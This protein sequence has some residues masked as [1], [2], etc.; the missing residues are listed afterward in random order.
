MCF[1]KAPTP[2][3]IAALPVA[4]PELVDD[5]ALADREKERERLR[6]AK[7]Y[8]STMLASGSANGSAPATSGTKTALDS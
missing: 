2:K 6:K 3:P 8:R 7:G 1:S 4:G 5:I